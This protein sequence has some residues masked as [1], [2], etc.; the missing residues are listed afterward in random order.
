MKIPVSLAALGL[1]LAGAGLTGCDVLNPSPTSS[2]ASDQALTTGRQA[3]LVLN[4]VYDRLQAQNDVSVIFNDLITDNAAW[5][6]SYPTWQQIDLYSYDAANVDIQGRWSGLYSA[7]ASANALI[8]KV[9]SIAT[10]GTFT[11]ARRTEIVG[12]AKALRAYCY[13]QLVNWFGDVPLTLQPTEAATGDIFPARSPVAAVYTQIEKD[14]TEAEAAMGTTNRAMSFMDVWAVKG[15]LSRVYLYQGK[16]GQAETKASEVIANTAFSLAPLST[17]WEGGGGSEILWA[18]TYIT[19]SDPNNMAFFAYPSNAGGRYEYAPTTDLYNAFS[20]ADNRRAFTI[21]TSGTTRVV[22]KY[23]R[24]ATKDDPV[25]LIRLAEMYLNRAEARAKKPTPDVPGA[26]ADLNAIRSRAGLG[27]LAGLTGTAL[28]D[29]I[30][31]ERRLELAFESQRW[32]DL[33]RTGKAL[34]TLPIPNADAKFL[35]F[36]IPQRERNVNSKLTQN[37]GY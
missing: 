30:D 1:L 26:L 2:I 6:G 27:A 33:K 21:R 19:G 31:G 9:P 15:L 35:L 22:G 7:I 11:E 18:L 8:A 10:S 20:A 13:L 5:T 34:S 23:F 24:T 29:A 14:L 12:E 4:S 16:W 28:T 37:P 17:L 36:P 3:E 25:Y 32:F